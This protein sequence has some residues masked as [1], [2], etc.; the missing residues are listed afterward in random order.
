MSVE[1]FNL[2]DSNIL[3]DR[4]ILANASLGCKVPPRGSLVREVCQADSIDQN[5]EKIECLCNDRSEICNSYDVGWIVV[6]EPVKIENCVK[7][8]I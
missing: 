2:N 8:S 6:Q 3:E 7:I 4:G 5:R 1:L